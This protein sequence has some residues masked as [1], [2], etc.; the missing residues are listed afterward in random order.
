MLMFTYLTVFYL[1]QHQNVQVADVEV[2]AGEESE[3]VVGGESSI[4]EYLHFK[5]GTETSLTITHTL[6][7]SGL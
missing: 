2:K 4:N 1:K 3:S 7:G 6:Q 5:I